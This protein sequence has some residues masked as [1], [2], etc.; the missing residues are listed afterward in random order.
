MIY[1]KVQKFYLKDYLK[2]LQEHIKY[3]FIRK[4]MLL[5]MLYI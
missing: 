2:D 4:L 5:K 1:I 3:L